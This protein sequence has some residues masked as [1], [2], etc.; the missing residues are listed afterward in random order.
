MKMMEWSNLKPS[1]LKALRKKWLQFLTCCRQSQYSSFNVAAGLNLH[2]VCFTKVRVDLH[3]CLVRKFNSKQRKEGSELKTFWCTFPS[4]STTYQLRVD[5][6][7][8]NFW[9]SSKFHTEMKSMISFPTTNTILDLHHPLPHHN[10][11]WIK[12][13]SLILFFFPR[14]RSQYNSTFTKQIY[15][16]LFTNSRFT[17][18]SSPW[19]FLGQ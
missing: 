13:F 9:W 12:D 16:I 14:A 8:I 10:K 2:K 1:N 15:Q 11:N 3:R 17:T 19:Q 4:E 18:L 6:T 7:N 5:S